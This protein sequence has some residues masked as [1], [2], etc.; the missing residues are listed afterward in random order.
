LRVAFSILAASCGLHQAGGALGDQR[1]QI[2][3]VDKVERVEHIA[4]GLGH[5]LAFGIAYQPCTYTVLNGTCGR[6]SFV[7]S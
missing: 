2:N 1:F 5:L 7:A 6:A 3:A 4:L